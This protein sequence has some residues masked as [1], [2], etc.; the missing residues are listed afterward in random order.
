[1]SWKYWLTVHKGSL[2]RDFD[3]LEFSFSLPRITIYLNTRF[4]GGEPKTSIPRGRKTR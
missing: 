3:Y 1:M 4:P 2:A